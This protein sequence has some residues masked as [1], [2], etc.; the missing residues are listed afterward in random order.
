MLSAR[1][2]QLSGIIVDHT[3]VFVVDFSVSAACATLIPHHFLKYYG[4]V[5]ECR[6][7]D[8]KYCGCLM[9]VGFFGGSGTVSM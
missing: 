7:V 6:S 8:K 2:L 5:F 3:S 9:L 1:Y 4:V